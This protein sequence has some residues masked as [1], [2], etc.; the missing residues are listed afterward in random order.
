[1]RSRR[2]RHGK[3]VMIDQNL[4]ESGH[5]NHKCKSSGIIIVE[6]HDDNS[7]SPFMS[8]YGRLIND[9]PEILKWKR[10]DP[11]WIDFRSISSCSEDC[12]ICEFAYVTW[13]TRKSKPNPICKLT[14]K[15][16]RFPKIESISSSSIVFDDNHS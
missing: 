5:I 9:C 12:S 7:D 1:M 3:R 14:F 11:N 2:N 13:F 6:K 4:S 8:E 15:H 16:C 10:N